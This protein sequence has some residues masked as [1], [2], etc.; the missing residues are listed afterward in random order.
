MRTFA[1]A[2]ELWFDYA[3]DGDVRDGVDKKTY[4]RESAEGHWND[5]KENLDDVLAGK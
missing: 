3:T 4:N 2:G 1:G 5:F